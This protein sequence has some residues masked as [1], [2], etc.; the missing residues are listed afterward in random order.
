MATLSVTGNIGWS[1]KAAGISRMTVIREQ[2]SND[3]FEMKMQHAFLELADRA[4]AFILKDA[5]ENAQSARWV[6]S[7][8]KPERYGDKVTIAG[9]PDAPIRHEHSILPFDPMKLSPDALREVLA[10]IDVPELPAPE[11]VEARYRVIRPDDD[12]SAA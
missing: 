1:A 9:D 8:W 11:E 4:E 5:A 12:D 6:L 10:L 7:K 3:E 2:R